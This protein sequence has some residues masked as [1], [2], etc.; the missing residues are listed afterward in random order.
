V[1]ATLVIYDLSNKLARIIIMHSTSI[2]V[3]VVLA[4]LTVAQAFEEKR[5]EMKKADKGKR[6]TRRARVHGTTHRN[7]TR[8]THCAGAQRYTKCARED[9]RG[10]RT[11]QAVHEYECVLCSPIESFCFAVEGPDAHKEKR[12]NKFEFIRFG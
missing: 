12:K 9:H 3:V 10:N 11:S 5:F 1:L 2:L 4:A 7:G 8:R 6:C